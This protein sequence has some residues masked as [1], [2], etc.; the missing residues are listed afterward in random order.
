[1]TEAICRPDVPLLAGERE[2]IEETARHNGNLDAV[3]ELVD[4]GCVVGE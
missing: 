4:G 2:M 1:M 3:R